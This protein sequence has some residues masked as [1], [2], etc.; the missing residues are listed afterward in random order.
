MSDAARRTVRTAVQSLLGLLAALPL[1]LNG[2]GLPQ[3]LPGLGTALA[4]STALTRLMALPGV[5]PL[6]PGWLRTAAPAQAVAA[7]AAAAPA[8]PVAPVA[9]EQPR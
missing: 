3:T 1:L 6:L 2:S 7:P 8:Q 9:Q 4:V 5:Q